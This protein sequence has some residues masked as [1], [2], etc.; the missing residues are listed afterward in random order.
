MTA[1]RSNL[2]KIVDEIIETGNP[3]VLERK[4]YRLKIVIVGKL[5]NLK[6]DIQNLKSASDF[7]AIFN[8][9]SSLQPYRPST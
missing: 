7:P 2:F 6:S 9:Q 3:V 8:L 1:L 5:D 4:G